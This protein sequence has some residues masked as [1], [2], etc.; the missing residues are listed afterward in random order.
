[1][2]E[3]LGDVVVAPADRDLAQHVRATLLK[4]VQPAR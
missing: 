4:L 2:S 1:V 3:A